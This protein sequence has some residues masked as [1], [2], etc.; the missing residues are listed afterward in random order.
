MA[1]STVGFRDP[2]VEFLLTAL[3]PT[4]PWSSPRFPHARLISGGSQY[5]CL[6]LVVISFELLLSLFTLL[7]SFVFIRT[8]GAVVSSVMHST[9]G[10]ILCQT[11]FP[12]LTLRHSTRSQGF[13]VGV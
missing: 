12:P 6:S 7:M 5:H 8:L 3:L 9:G 13:F 11:V 1:G 10:C 4:R 2:C